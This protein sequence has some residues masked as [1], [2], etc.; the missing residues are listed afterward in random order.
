MATTSEQL[1]R[2]GERIANYVRQAA[3]HEA[4]ASEARQ[5]ASELTERFNALVV[6]GVQGAAKP[7]KRPRRDTAQR[8]VSGTAAA[9]AATPG[10]L[11]VTQAVRDWAKQHAR[12]FRL[13]EVRA[14]MHA[15][16]PEVTDG[17]F[18]HLVH[19]KEIRKLDRGL[20][21]HPDNYEQFAN[22]GAVAGQEEGEPATTH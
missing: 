11:G 7:A 18:Y 14:V 10:Y 8:I 17:P 22:V 21:I 6:S 15:V 20:F 16:N 5:R 9:S 3:E 19:R 12:P 4:K 1:K 2:I 13:V